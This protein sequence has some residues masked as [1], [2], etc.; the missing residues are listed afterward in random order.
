MLSLSASLS[1]TVSKSAACSSTHVTQSNCLCRIA[2][3]PKTIYCL[4]V[5]HL[6]YDFMIQFILYLYIY[7]Y[8][9]MYIYYTV[10]TWIT[11]LFFLGL[12]STVVFNCFFFSILKLCLVEQGGLFCFVTLLYC[13]VFYYIYFPCPF[14]P[15]FGYQ[16]PRQSTVKYCAIFDQ[17]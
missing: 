11:Y 3:K 7:L 13:V 6:F 17:Q 14:S 1:I 15:L 16:L 5:W 4:K 12:G 9:F 8:I 2:H 10:C